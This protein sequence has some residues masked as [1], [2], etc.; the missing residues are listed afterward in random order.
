MTNTLWWMSLMFILLAGAF[1]QLG[2][3]PM[4]FACVMATVFC[5]FT[6]QIISEGRR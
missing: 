4:V 5:V 2:V 6:I 3:A 1:G